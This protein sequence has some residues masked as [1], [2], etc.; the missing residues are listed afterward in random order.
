MHMETSL[1]S[2]PGIAECYGH[3]R[4][5]GSWPNISGTKF[6]GV[7]G[8]F[9]KKKYRYTFDNLWNKKVMFRLQLNGRE[10]DLLQSFE[11]IKITT[12]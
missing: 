4:G 2:V 12:K 5:R 1:E 8:P 3:C 10:F 9:V 7:D 6:T 11:I